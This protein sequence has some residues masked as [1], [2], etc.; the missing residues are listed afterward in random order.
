MVYA[1]LGLLWFLVILKRE[2]NHKV[3]IALLFL[4][5]Y[6]IVIEGIQG[7]FIISRNFDALDILANT[8]G[9]FLGMGAYFIIKQRRWL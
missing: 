6:G 2:Q 3:W 1:V 7:M 9:L 4:V 5:F 8:L